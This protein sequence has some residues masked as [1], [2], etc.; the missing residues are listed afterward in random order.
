MQEESDLLL[1]FQQNRVAL[2]QFQET[3][4]KLSEA[5]DLNNASDIG[6]YLQI[7]RG[8]YHLLEGNNI[9]IENTIRHD[10]PA[11]FLLRS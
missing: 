1:Y 11:L 7:L 3:I 5:I 6:L 4:E 9:N 2:D 8:C 10:N